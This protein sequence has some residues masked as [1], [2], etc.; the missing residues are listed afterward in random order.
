M[1]REKD[2][3]GISEEDIWGIREDRELDVS[4]DVVDVVDVVVVVTG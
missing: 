2:I 4:V 3:S 1:L